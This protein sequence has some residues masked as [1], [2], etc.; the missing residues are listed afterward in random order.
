MERLNLWEMKT[1]KQIIVKYQKGVRNVDDVKSFFSD[2]RKCGL[3]EGF[4]PDTDFANYLNKEGNDLFGDDEVNSLSNILN[5]CFKVCKKEKKNIYELAQKQFQSN[6]TKEIQKSFLKEIKRCYN[7]IESFE[8]LL[9][10]KI[11]SQTQDYLNWK[12]IED[13]EKANALLEQTKEMLSRD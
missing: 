11:E 7:L 10:K 8:G 6:G 5:T 12:H 13:V 1:A 4:H 3:S 9:N 2:L